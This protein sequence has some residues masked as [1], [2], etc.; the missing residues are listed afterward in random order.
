MECERVCEL[1]AVFHGDSAEHLDVGAEVIID[2]GQAGYGAHIHVEGYAPG[3]SLPAARPGIHVVEMDEYASLEDALARASSVALSVATELSPAEEAHTLGQGPGSAVGLELGPGG[4]AV[5]TAGE[6]RIGVALCHCGD[7][8]SSVVDFNQVTG[9]LLQLPGVRSVRSIPQACTNEG[10]N[11]IAAQIREDGLDRIVLAACRC[12]GLE[13]I[14]FSC[15]ERRVLCQLSLSSNPAASSGTAVEFVNIREHCAKVHRDEPAAATRKAADIISSGVARAAGPQQPSNEPRPVEGSV[16]V[17]GAGLRGLAAARDLKALGYSVAVV[18]D[19]GIEGSEQQD[20]EYIEGRAALVKNLEAQGIHIMPWPQDLAL[21]GAPGGYVAVARN[22]S[23]VN[24][25]RAGA[26]ILDIQEGQ[27]GIHPAFSGISADNL[28]GRII[29]K[30]TNRERLAGPDSAALRGLTIKETAGVFVMPPDEY[31]P[32]EDQVIRGSATAARASA[33]LRRGTI[34]PRA[35]AVEIDRKLCRGCGECA[36]IC[37]FIEL[38]GSDDDG[39]YACVDKA[40]C[41][42]CGACV[43]HCP[44]GAIIQPS[45]TDGQLAATLEALLGKHARGVGAK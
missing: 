35:I 38:K 9:E 31:E 28:L 12:C 42:G 7:S 37:S 32:P 29:S 41:L 2:F 30:E 36:A 13:Q 6:D 33:Y 15:T 39:A 5:Q 4:K 18:S 21:E 43:A 40:L 24:R 17:L 8:I 26:L 22:G 11:L 25:I 14:C 1:R 45:Q 20:P 23:Q 27:G 19:P 3:A 10:A 34:S 44:A 16:L